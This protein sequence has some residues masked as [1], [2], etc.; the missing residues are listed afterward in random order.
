MSDAAAAIAKRGVGAEKCG[1]LEAKYS[2]IRNQLLG[3]TADQGTISKLHGSIIK[4]LGCLRKKG[5]SNYQTEESGTTIGSKD[6][7]Y[8]R[9]LYLYCLC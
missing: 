2:Y 8:R 5:Q 1:R 7:G 3:S 4:G 9:R 6:S